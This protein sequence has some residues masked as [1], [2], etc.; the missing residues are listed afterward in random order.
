MGELRV[1]CG[2]DEGGEVPV[3]FGDPKAMRE[4]AEVLDRWLG[5]GHRYF[6]VRTPDRAVYILRHDEGVDSWQIYCFE[7]AAAPRDG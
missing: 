6:R 4:V 1:V 5:E 7:N 3:R 2:R